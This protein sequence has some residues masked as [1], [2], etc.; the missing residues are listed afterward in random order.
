MQGSGRLP[1]D[2]FMST[3]AKATEFHPNL[4]EESVQDGTCS[5]K[6]QWSTSGRGDLQ[7]MKKLGANAVIF[8]EFIQ[9]VVQQMVS[10][11]FNAT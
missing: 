10:I 4:A 1:N 7:I 5:W 2:D 6:A 9:C 11:S 3:S 8:S